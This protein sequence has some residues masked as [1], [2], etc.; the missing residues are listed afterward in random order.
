MLEANRGRVRLHGVASAERRTCEGV[1]GRLRGSPHTAL[2]ARREGIGAHRL[3][4]AARGPVDPI[5]P[6]T[7]LNLPA[8]QAA[9]DPHYQGATP[10]FFVPG[11]GAICSLS[12]EQAALVAASTKHVN[13]TGGSGDYNQPELYTLV[14]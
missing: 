6:G 10:G 9:S 4:A 14:G 8:D 7:S 1:V 11:L 5:A 12:P 3:S 2:E 13:H